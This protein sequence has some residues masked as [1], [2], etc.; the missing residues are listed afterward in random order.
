MRLITE[1]IISKFENH[2][3]LSQE[4]KGFDAEVFV[5]YFNPMGTSTWLIT[6]VER[7]GDD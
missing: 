3:F 5:K 1:E 7:E 4:G 6:E 2:L